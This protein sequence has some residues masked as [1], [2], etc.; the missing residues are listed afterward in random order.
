M[1]AFGRWGEAG[2]SCLQWMPRHGKAARPGFDAR[3]FLARVRRRVSVAVQRGHALAV[4]NALQR[5][6]TPAGVVVHAGRLAPAWW[7]RAWLP[8]AG[9]A[10]LVFQ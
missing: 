2:T 10:F 6:G 9:A 4:A 8:T 5:A 7:G 3:T 1:E